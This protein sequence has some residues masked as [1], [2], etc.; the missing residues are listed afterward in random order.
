MLKKMSNPR[1]PNQKIMMKRMKRM[2][3]RMR[4]RMMKT[5]KMRSKNKMNNQFK[6]PSLLQLPQ[7]L[8]ILILLTSPLQRSLRRKGE[9]I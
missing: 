1:I 9:E 7:L 8:L 6:Y 4:M 5:Q 3:T 2:I